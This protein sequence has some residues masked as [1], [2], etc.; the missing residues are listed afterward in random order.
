MDSVPKW[1]QWRF[2]SKCWF[3]H[4]LTTR[5]N[6]IATT[7]QLMMKMMPALTLL[8]NT[9][10]PK[11]LSGYSYTKHIRRNVLHACCLGQQLVVSG[12]QT[13]LNAIVVWH[14]YAGQQPGF[15]A[16]KQRKNLSLCCH[17]ETS[18]GS[19]KSSYC[20]TTQSTFLLGK[21]TGQC[22][23]PLSFI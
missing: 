5:N 18:S 11:H 19:Y 15:L 22:S 1:Q 14:A 7:L 8:N 12:L 13:A 6:F 16:K 20:V 21:T 9:R 3:V 17:I 2:Y 4:R 10:Y 23:W